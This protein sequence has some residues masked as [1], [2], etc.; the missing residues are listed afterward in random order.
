MLDVDV[1]LIDQ[2][3]DERPC[4]DCGDVLVEQSDLFP[5]NWLACQ[6]HAYM[7]LC[8]SC[9]TARSTANRLANP[10]RQRKYVRESHRK[11]IANG[12]NAAQDAK[13]RAWKR[14]ATG[15]W[16]DAEA[17]KAIYVER[18]RKG[19]KYHVDHILPLSRGG[20]HCSA[21]LRVTSAP[22]NL[23]KGAQLPEALPRALLALYC[24]YPAMLAVPQ[25]DAEARAFVC[26]QL[27]N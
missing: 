12:K 16:T 3:Y 26:S 24:A 9:T 27:P 14:E 11:R 6:A 25:M 1:Y 15:L 23:S 4:R 13:R 10:N 5:Y 19:H 8:R 7:H 17:C 20:P 22:E 21:N 2:G 18:A